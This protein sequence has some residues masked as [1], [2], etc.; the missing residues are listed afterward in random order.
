MNTL[1]TVKLSEL[2]PSKTNP[3][4]HFPETELKELQA[5]ITENGL[6][7]ALIVRKNSKGFEIVD[8]ERRYR[9]LKALGHES[10]MIE[11]RELTDAE[12]L[13]YQLMTFLH[14]K[15]ITP[16]EEANAYSELSTKGMSPEQIAAKVGKPVHHIVRILRLL[17]L[18]PEA[19]KKYEEGKLPIGHAMEICRLQ[20]QDQERAVKYI[21]DFDH[22]GMSDVVSISHLKDFIEDEIHLDLRKIS[23][24][25]TDPKL[26]EK[27][28]ACTHCVKR[29]GF[30]VGLFP[31]IQQADTCTD[32][33]CFKEKVEA[34]IAQE[35]ARLKEKKEKVVE[36]T[37]QYNKPADHPHAI[38]VR[39]YKEVKGKPCKYAVNGIAVAGSDRGKVTLICNN[40][41]CSKHWGNDYRH[42]QAVEKK[43]EKKKSPEQLEKE[44]IAKLKEEMKQEK[45][46]RFIEAVKDELPSY[47]PSVANKTLYANI[48]EAFF[49][50]WNIR[51][52]LA[53]AMKLKKGIKLEKLPP[54][55]LIQ[56]LYLGSFLFRFSNSNEDE[57]L[58]MQ[59]AKEWEVDTATIKKDIH[60]IV[61]QE[62]AEKM[63]PL[64]SEGTA[65]KSDLALPEKEEE[66]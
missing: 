10:V 2:H 51:Q 16:L 3:R 9:A 40:K 59:T 21:F 4:K 17:K 19:K 56:G 55:K 57:K 26:V 5:S 58:I 32:P 66:E 48:L 29:T 54:K 36:F 44:R 49:T 22:L 35:K 41:E 33:K 12:V 8:G 39:S 18:I 65:T 27:A 47:V 20:P 31:D 25:K 30:N 42:D 52:D 38:T 23:F 46:H 13:E 64:Q 7:Q 50:D 45:E 63:K 37:P 1:Q 60:K 15:D 14:R 62:Y 43:T 53:D 6:Q 61:E 34:H 28:G 11:L 24:S